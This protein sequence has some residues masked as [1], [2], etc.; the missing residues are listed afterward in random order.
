MTLIN[1]PSS[2]TLPFTVSELITDHNPGIDVVPLHGPPLLQQRRVPCRRP[3][4]WLFRLIRCRNYLQLLNLPR[5]TTRQSHPL[6]RPGRRRSDLSN[7]P[8]LPLVLFLLTLVTRSSPVEAA[9]PWSVPL[10]CTLGFLHC[11]LLVHCFRSGIRWGF[12]T[13][14]DGH[15]RR[16]VVRLG[17]GVAGCVDWGVFFPL[18]FGAVGCSCFLAA[19]SGVRSL[20]SK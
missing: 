2:I 12:D 14:G 4:C 15:P 17:G 7:F 19:G 6:R 1:M 8:S 13:E 20:V 18:P 9:L 3:L 10:V 11:S 5:S 16:A